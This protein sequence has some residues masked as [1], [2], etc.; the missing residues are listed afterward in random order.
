[1]CLLL[2]NGI[3]TSSGYLIPN[4]SLARRTVNDLFKI[5]RM[6]K[7]INRNYTRMLRA[8]LNKSK[9]KTPRNN[10][11]T[12]HLPTITKKKNIHSSNLLSFLLRCGTTTYEWGHPLL[13]S[14]TNHYNTRS[15]FI[16]PEVPGTRHAG[17]CRRGKD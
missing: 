5:T 6:L 17:H 11:C 7:K 14:L 16:P 12:S 8:I 15:A 10:S 2:F 4:L 3:S 1:M 13:V 9:S